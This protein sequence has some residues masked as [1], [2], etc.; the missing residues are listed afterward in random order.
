MVKKYATTL[1]A[2]TE[3]SHSA[4]IIIS[5][6]STIRLEREQIL[7]L[8]GL[9]QCPQKTI[10]EKFVLNSIWLNYGS[11]VIR[12]Q[13]LPM[14]IC[15]STL[16][17][18]LHNMLTSLECLISF[19]KGTFTQSYWVERT[20][21]RLKNFLP[22]E[23]SKHLQQIMLLTKKVSDALFP[24][25]MRITLN[26]PLDLQALPFFDVKATSSLFRSV[27]FCARR[28]FCSSG[29]IYNDAFV[30]E[31]MLWVLDPDT[32][33]LYKHIY[34]Y[35]AVRWYVETFAKP[36]YNSSGS[37]N[38]LKSLLYAAH[39]HHSLSSFLG[40]DSYTCLKL[41]FDFV[42]WKDYQNMI[43]YFQTLENDKLLRM[44]I[45]LVCLLLRERMILIF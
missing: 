23:T 31:F 25:R 9:C 32:S 29:E 18:I 30:R 33:V 4:R 10:P 20:N 11:M 6:Y 40:L 19:H 5:Y 35:R 24:C 39:H 7:G 16:V 12:L 22:L 17:S 2:S 27:V 26:C 1:F 37:V 21:Q 45:T 3:L 38:P 13:R 36:I 44:K 14:V 8:F 43:Q 41:R 42:A 15:K 34:Q 28:F